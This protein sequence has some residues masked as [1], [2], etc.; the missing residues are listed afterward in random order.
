M[1]LENFKKE[2][3]ILEDRKAEAYRKLYINKYI[4]TYAE[5][6]KEYIEDLYPFS[7]GLRYMGYLWD[8]LKSP[9]FIH[10]EQIEE[11]RKILKK[12]LI[13]WDNH[14]KDLIYIKDYWKFG[15]KTMVRVDYNL[16]LDHAH[17]FPE[18]VY[19]TDETLQWTI[20]FTHEDGI[21]NR[22]LIMQVGL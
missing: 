5:D 11:Y 19:L 8:F 20:V 21:N 7:D 4:D 17:F 9:T 3:Q 22:R 15:K 13:F 12:V 2:I 1:E 14:S 16:F 18:D 6:Y 10:E